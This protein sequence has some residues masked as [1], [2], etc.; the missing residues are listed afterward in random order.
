MPAK[1]LDFFHKLTKELKANNI[2][3]EQHEHH[4]S[5]NGYN[6]Y[7]KEGEYVMYSSGTGL[8]CDHEVIISPKEVVWYIS[9]SVKGLKEE[10]NFVLDKKGNFL[11]RK[12]R[13]LEKHKKFGNHAKIINHVL[14]KAH[15]GIIT[16]TFALLRIKKALK[17][18]P[19]KKITITTDSFLTK[20]A[21]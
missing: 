2:N 11:F 17:G 8:K 9:S 18:F 21:I 3:Y 14:N 16:P 1:I 10:V 19:S 13:F 20:Y 12:R 6:I 7:F 5:A 4:V 15:K